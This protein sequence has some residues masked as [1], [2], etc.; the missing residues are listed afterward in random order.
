MTTSGVLGLLVLAAIGWGWFDSMRALERARGA[1]RARCEAVG[2][3]LLDDTVVL[4]RLR[5]RRDEAGRLVPWRLYRFEFTG[6]GWSRHRGRVILRGGHIERLE[7]EPW[8][9]ARP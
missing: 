2:V 6:N 4:R 8:Q 7:M 5:L 1:A 3:A 9:E